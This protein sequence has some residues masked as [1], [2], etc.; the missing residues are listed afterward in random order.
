VERGCDRMSLRQLGRQTKT[1]TFGVGGL[2]L[3]E[4]TLEKESC[5]LAHKTEMLRRFL[6]T[7]RFL[8]YLQM[9]VQVLAF[10]R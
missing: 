7:R 3:R 10:M 9:N 4:R 8:P 6:L 5:L 2:H 1:Q